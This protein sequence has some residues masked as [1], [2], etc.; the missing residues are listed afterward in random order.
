M[1]GALT[2][3]H[4]ARNVL[5]NPHCLCPVTGLGK[6]SNHDVLGNG[7]VAEHLRNLE[8]AADAHFA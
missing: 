4:L 2:Q 1:A 5:G 6:G 3:A 8:G 7:H